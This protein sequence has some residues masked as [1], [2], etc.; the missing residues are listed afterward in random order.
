MAGITQLAFKGL[1]ICR[2]SVVTRNMSTQLPVL[3]SYWSSSCSWRVR[4]ALTHKKI[5]YQLKATSLLTKDKDHVYTNDYKEV[6]PMQTVPALQIDGHTL[7]D[8]VAIMH[9]L[10]ETRPEPSLLPQDPAQRAKVREIVELICSAIQPL[11]NVGVL[12]R[13]G[14]DKRLE[15]AQEWITRGFTA[16]EKVLSQS[17]GKFCVG[18]ELTMA[19]VCLV[20]QFFNANRYKVDL[21]PYPTIVKLAEDLGK[22]ESFKSCHP[23]LQPDCPPKVAKN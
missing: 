9:Y 3:Y 4:I 19:D 18:N 7:R 23:Y 11:Q 10:E 14:N 15:W 22:L 2:S 20:P 17:A 6:N 8:S 12:D 16:L 1:Q 21:S 13:V 5:D